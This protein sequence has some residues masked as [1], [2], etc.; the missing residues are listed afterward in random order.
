ML[1]E[2][3]VAPGTVSLYVVFVEETGLNVI[4]G[5]VAMEEEGEEEA[6]ASGII[7]VEEEGEAEGKAIGTAENEGDGEGEGDKLP[8][9]AFAGH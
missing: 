6:E 5:T 4:I 9:V 2:N 1:L 3:T 8:L 7:V